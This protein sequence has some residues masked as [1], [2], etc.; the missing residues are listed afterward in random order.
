M[1]AEVTLRGYLSDLADIA[2]LFKIRELSAYNWLKFSLSEFATLSLQDIG[3]PVRENKISNIPYNELDLPN[4][5]ITQNEFTDYLN[6]RDSKC[7]YAFRW[8]VRSIVLD[9]EGAA[10][11]MGKIYWEWPLDER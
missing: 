7:G 8:D 4:T 9:D 5:V 6:Q 1:D 3:I 11:D 10:V 2:R